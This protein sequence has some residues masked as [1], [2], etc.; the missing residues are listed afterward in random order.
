MEF[1]FSRGL[2][3]IAIALGKFGSP[4]LPVRLPEAFIF[5]FGSNSTGDYGLVTAALAL[6]YFG[7]IIGVAF[8]RQG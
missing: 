8:C 3:V 2:T 7:A 1:S 4:A 5:C 6:K